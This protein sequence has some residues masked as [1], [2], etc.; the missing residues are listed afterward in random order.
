MHVFK[1]SIFLIFF[2]FFFDYFFFFQMKSQQFQVGEQPHWCGTE[3]AIHVPSLISTLL[4]E[5]FAPFPTFF[6]SY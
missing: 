5:G 3:E 1:N 2:L 6:P 4:N